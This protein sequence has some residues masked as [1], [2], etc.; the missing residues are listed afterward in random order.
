MADIPRSPAAA[1]LTLSSDVPAVIGQSIDDLIRPLFDADDGEELSEWC[2]GILIAFVHEYNILSD[3]HSYPP[4][5]RQYELT[6]VRG[7]AEVYLVA[8]GADPDLVAALR[9]AISI[10]GEEMSAFEIGVVLAMLYQVNLL[11]TEHGLASMGFENFMNAVRLGAETFSDVGIVK[12]PSTANLTIT[13]VAPVVTPINL[14][15]PT[16]EL[17]L[18]G[19]VPYVAPITIQPDA[20]NLT[21]ET[22]A[23]DFTVL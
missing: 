9:E 22:D 4:I 6:L 15:P 16:A 17:F 12:V 19:W 5:G 18:S 2:V 8:T 3:N 23:P 1:D 21:I 7:L 10:E 20:A 11:R 14:S 13:S